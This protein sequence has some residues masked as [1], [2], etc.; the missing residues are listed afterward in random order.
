MKMKG[1]N[2]RKHLFKLTLCVSLAFTFYLSPFTLKAQNY[3]SDDTITEYPN[4]G[5][6]YHDMFEGRKTSNG[7]IFDQN[8]F[9]AAHWKIKLGTYVMVTNRNNGMQVIVRVNDRC[10]KR[11]VFDMSHR[12]ANAIGI[13]GMQ[14]V[15]VRLLQGDW[16]DRWAA[17]ETMFDSVSS[18]LTGKQPP[19]QETPK[20]QA[21]TASQAKADKAQPANEKQEKTSKKEDNSGTYGITIGTAASHGEA[22]DMIQKLPEPYRDKVVIETVDDDTLL[23]S[24]D[25]NLPKGSADELC[26]ALRHTF[27]ECGVTRKK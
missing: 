17:Q 14:P 21:A 5:T 16:Y 6:Y 19:V 15:T 18:R 8:K 27:P 13:K 26:R 20:P 12:A 9:T 23:L 25:I 3:S 2:I 11:G 4:K 24:L 22:Y 7:E 1:R 10:P